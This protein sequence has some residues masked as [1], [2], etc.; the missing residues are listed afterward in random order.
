V[1]ATYLAILIG[2][3]AMIAAACGYLVVKLTS[4][5]E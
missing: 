3:F 4:R 2:A 1:E 5:G